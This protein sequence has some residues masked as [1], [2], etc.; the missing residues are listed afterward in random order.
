MDYGVFVCPGCSGIHREFSHK[1]KGITMSNFTDKEVE[2]VKANGNKV[3]FAKLMGGWSKSLFP[4]PP[5]T[6]VM[7]FKEFMRMKYQ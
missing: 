3:A 2:F 1:A 5:K 7:K 4:E 6:E